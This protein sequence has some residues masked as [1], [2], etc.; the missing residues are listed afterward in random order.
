MFGSIKKIKKKSSQ[1]FLI[2]FFSVFISSFLFTDLTFSQDISGNIEGRITDTL[3]INLAGVNVSLESSNLQ[4]S[5]GTTTNEKGFFQILNLPVG[6]YALT[7]NSVGYHELKIEHVQ[8]R[9]GKTTNLGIVTLTEQTIDLP[10]V[11]VVGK[12]LFID[13]ASTSFGG[14][15]IAKDFEQ[16]PVD[17]NYKSI[18]TLL[19]QTNLSYFGDEANIG[20]A[21]GFENKY[22]VDGIEVT[23]PLIGADA[24]NLPYN[25]IQEVEVKSGGYNVDARSALGGLMNVVT[26]SGSNEFHGSA[27]GFY[28]S[29]KLAENKKLGLSDVTQGDYSNYDFGFGIGGPIILDQLWFY[30]AYNPTFNNRDV[31][32]PSFGKQ[33]DKILRHLFAAKLNWRTSEKLQLIFTA[34]GDPAFQDA[35]GKDIKVPPSDLLNID[36]YLKDV[37]YGGINLSFKGTYTLN[38][39]FFLDGFISRVDRNEKVEPSTPGGSEILFQDYLNDAWSGGILFTTDSYRYSYVG[40]I[41]STLMIGDHII[42]GGAEY[43]TNHANQTYD[44][45]YIERY[46]SVYYRE[47]IGNASGEVYNRIPSLFIQNSWRIFNRLNITTGIRWE[48]QAAVGSNGEVAQSFLVPLQPRLGL[49][50]LLNDQ[51]SHRVFGSFGRFTQEFGLWQSVQYHSDEGYNYIIL[52]QND[53][54]INN[55]GG[56]TLYNFK[57]TIRPEV[58]DLEVQ[59]FDEFSLGYETLIGDNFRAGIQGVYRTL[60]QCIDDVWFE[61]EDRYQYGNPGSG[62]L[63]AWPE[64]K[65]E[66]TALVITLER[67]GDEQFNFLASY[68]LSK[69]YGNYEGLFD[70]FK[71]GSAPNENASFDDLNTADINSTGLLPNDRT[72]VFKFS[73]YY[74]FPFG[75]TAGIFFIAQSGTPL[76]ELAN[77]GFGIKFFTERGTVGRTPFIWDLNARLTYNLQFINSVNSKIILDFFHIASQQKPVDIVQKKYNGIDENGNP[78]WPYDKYGEVYRYQPSLSM[79]LGIEVS[80]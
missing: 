61:E 26:F 59:Y 54:R 24:T 52:F 75:L 23:D 53:P 32:V 44:Y 19:P 72:H 73:G 30:A 13:P 4:G 41:T 31:D 46:D 39:N 11:T 25:F 2:L 48:S 21:T 63:S 70:Y 40:R 20:G 22:Y 55:T 51:G 14:N 47:S 36:P 5:R 69:N 62:F 67:R 71:H 37:T 66:Y 45:H 17:R 43:K 65:R 79:R 49:V 35:V 60:R 28:T 10:E 38:K 33:Q 76:S 50:Y 6:E 57:H 18:T 3:E 80:F 68:V 58:K 7:F 9:L 1:L 34:T 15:I 74:L 12:K 42:N 29:N 64:P 78:I 16:L 27:F 8:I 77:T 56:D